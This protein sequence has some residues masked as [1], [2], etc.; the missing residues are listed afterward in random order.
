MT[1]MVT[2]HQHAALK[3]GSEGIKIETYKTHLELVEAVAW[4]A[5]I[6]LGGGAQHVAWLRALADK[7][8]TQHKEDDQPNSD[9]AE[10]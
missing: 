4:R 3:V 8:E 1:A 10:F 5:W 2:Y 9:P 7:F 6:E